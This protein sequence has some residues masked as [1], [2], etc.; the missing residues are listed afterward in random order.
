MKAIANRVSRGRGGGLMVS[1]LALYSNNPN[2][3]PAGFKNNFLLEKTEI[4]DLEAEVDPS[5]KK[6]RVVIVKIPRKCTKNCKSILFGKTIKR[7][8][9]GF[10]QL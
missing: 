2:L 1:V 8:Q 3:N 10:L 5:L 4:N 6:F 9:S 7:G